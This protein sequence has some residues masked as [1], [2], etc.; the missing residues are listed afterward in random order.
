M[1]ADLVQP[2]SSFRTAAQL[3]AL[4]KNPAVRRIALNIAKQAG[5]AIVNRRKNRVKAGKR[6]FGK[7]IAQKLMKAGVPL[8]Q[9]QWKQENS[10]VPVRLNR[11]VMPTQREGTTVERAEN[12]MELSG[13]PWRILTVKLCPNETDFPTLV[14][15]AEQYQRFWFNRITLN[16]DNVEGMSYKGTVGVCVIKD[17]SSLDSITNWYEFTQN[18]KAVWWNAGM[19]FSKVLTDQD[20]NL[21]FREGGCIMPADMKTQDLTDPLYVQGFL[22]IAVADCEGTGKIGR[23]TVTYH[24]SL[25]GPVAP[26]AYN[27]ASL[28]VGTAATTFAGIVDAADIDYAS[29]KYDLFSPSADILTVTANVPGDFL[30]T[31]VLTNTTAGT[32]FASDGQHST[33]CTVSHMY[34]GGSNTCTASYFLVRRLD[35][36]PCWFNIGHS[37]PGT[38]TWTHIG[39]HRLDRFDKGLTWI[40]Q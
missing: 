40:N 27:T 23:L 5:V 19:G 29:P 38:S 21:Q 25:T 15:T 2:A 1:G 17:L 3:A 36:Q 13:S 24:C 34:V 14:K 8:P 32:V 33:N 7:R 31:T 9:Q 30:C 16:Y 22:V 18:T 11:A 20:F 6:Y 10:A 26:P 39:I 28:N 35:N 37:H 12:T 4:A